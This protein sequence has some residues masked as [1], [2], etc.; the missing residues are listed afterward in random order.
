[1]EPF[2]SFRH[3]LLGNPE[4]LVLVVMPLIAAILFTIND[5]FNAETLAERKKI[6]STLPLIILMWLLYWLAVRHTSQAMLFGGV[7]WIGCLLMALK[8]VVMFVYRKLIFTPVRW[9]AYQKGFDYDR[10][11]AAGYSE[12]EI[13]KEVE[14]L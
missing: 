1:M 3:W 5:I 13:A 2:I 10:A 6:A 8:N 7:F 12:E 14:N 9:Q 11:R 4:Y